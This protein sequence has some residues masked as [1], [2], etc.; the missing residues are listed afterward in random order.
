MGEIDSKHVTDY[1]CYYDD[2]FPTEYYELLGRLKKEYP[3]AKYALGTIDT[4]ELIQIFDNYEN[5][6]RYIKIYDCSWKYY[7]Y[8]ISSEG[9]NHFQILDKINNEQGTWKSIDYIGLFQTDYDQ[10]PYRRYRDNFK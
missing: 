3:K 1:D 7:L 4:F 5:V 6:L 10:A 9:Y 2:P 8:H